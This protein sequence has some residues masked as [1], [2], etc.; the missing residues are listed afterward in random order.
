MYVK[1]NVYDEE[2]RELKQ[3]LLQ[4][5]GLIEKTLSR[6]IE[7]LKNVDADLAREIIA[8][9]YKIN[10]LEHIVEEK[11]V[12]LILRQQPVAKDLRRIMAALK[13]SSDLERMADLSVD[14]AKV[15]VRIEGQTLIKPLVDIPKMA[16]KAQKMVSQSL[17]SYIDENVQEATELARLDDEVDNLY[18]SIITELTKYMLEKPESINQALQLSFVGHYIERIADHATNVAESVVYLVQG[19]RPDLNY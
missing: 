11:A 14:I 4:M 19:T 8:G 16:E 9:D 15:A 1:R 12:G 13:I 10:E 2:L 17:N 3:V 5:G 7:A 6:S 18:N